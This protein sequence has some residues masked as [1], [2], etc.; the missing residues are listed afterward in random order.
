ME[1][2]YLREYAVGKAKD[3]IVDKFKALYDNS[4]VDSVELCTKGMVILTKEV[5]KA[6][7]A[8]PK[9]ESLRQ[10]KI[11]LKHAESLR[12]EAAKIPP[13]RW[14]DHFYRALLPS[15][16]TI[17]N[18][19]KAVVQERDIKNMTRNDVLADFDKVIATIKL[20]IKTLQSNKEE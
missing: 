1:L 7:Q 19:T 17:F 8:K 6:E 11:T 15:F 13:D 5:A 9:S 18:Y 12:K 10:Y 16:G 3:L 2:S 14:T 4:T 20:R